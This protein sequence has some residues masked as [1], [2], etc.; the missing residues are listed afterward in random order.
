MPFINSKI[1]VPVPQEKREVIKTEL[2]KAI[3]LLNKPESFLMIGA[4]TAETSK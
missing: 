3:S 2:G 1:T 4:G